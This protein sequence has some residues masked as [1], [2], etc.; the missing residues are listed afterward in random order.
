MSVETKN[1]QPVKDSG[2]AEK[3]PDRQRKEFVKPELKSWGAVDKVT[4]FSF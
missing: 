3:Q 4:G 2:G 1:L